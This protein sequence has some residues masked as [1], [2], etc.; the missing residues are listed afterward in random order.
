[1]SSY[2]INYTDFGVVIRIA[3]TLRP[4]AARRW[5]EELSP[6]LEGFGERFHVLLDLRGNTPSESDEV[7]E[8]AVAVVRQSLS[9]SLTRLAIVTDN[10]AMRRRMERIL[11]AGGEPELVR[12]L[13]AQ[14]NPNWKA[15][16]EAWLQREAKQEL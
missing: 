8:E 1:M 12:W 9:T 3:D 7:F 13:D 14:T 2:L 4:Q 15:A 5:R 16:A 11:K 6:M 10:E